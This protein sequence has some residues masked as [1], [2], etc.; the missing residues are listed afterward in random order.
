MDSKP[1]TS[2]PPDT[3]GGYRIIRTLT[4]GRSYLAIAPGGSDWRPPPCGA[5]CVPFPVPFDGALELGAALAVAGVPLASRTAT[6][7][8]AIEK[9]LRA[10]LL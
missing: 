6:A 3:I 4:P 1:P 9:D 5:G 7:K 8:L 2:L 10:V